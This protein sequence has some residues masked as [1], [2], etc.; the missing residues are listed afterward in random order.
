MSRENVEIA[1]AAFAA[2]NV[3][4]M[5]A[6]RELYDPDAIARPLENWPPR[7]LTSRAGR[8]RKAR[9]LGA[10]PWEVYGAAPPNREGTGMS[11]PRNRSRSLWVAALAGCVL[12]IV[13]AAPAG[14]WMLDF[15]SHPV[16]T[17]SNSNSPKSQQ[18]T[19]P[20]AAKF[21]LGAGASVPQISNLALNKID[22]RELRDDDGRPAV[23]A[24]AAETDS[25]SARWALTTRAW[26]FTA[27]QTRPTV[28][29]GAPYVKDVTIA[30]NQS[31]S[32]SNSPKTVEAQCPAGT[33]GIGGGYQIEGSNQVAA[34]SVQR[35]ASGLRAR[36]QETDATAGRWSIQAHAI[37]AN[38]TTAVSTATYAGGKP[39]GGFI[40]VISP[41]V[42]SA[43]NSLNKHGV[44]ATCPG[45]PTLRTF[46]VGGGATVRAA[47]AGD[48][49]APADVAITVSRPGGDVANATTWTASAVEVDPTAANWQLEV[50]ARCTTLTGA[51]LP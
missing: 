44:T 13:L 46:V 37:C 39:D 28:G 3:G 40:A 25:E 8:G 21:A 20:G 19:C 18:F 23:L 12:A 30:R 43:T 48:P 29:G 38:V 11:Q 45:D 49:P 31:S 2:W 50:T 10:R 9:N 7:A 6:L 51:P 33:N 17:P 35:L 42:K 5:D 24:A 14:A 41:V 22:L 26:C 16:L 15:A 34:Y 36:A 47:G 32:N 27:T 4:D 1:Q